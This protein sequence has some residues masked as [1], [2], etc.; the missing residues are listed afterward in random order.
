MMRHAVGAVVVTAMVLGCNP[1]GPSMVRI[2][3]NVAAEGPGA[4]LGSTGDSLHA[5]Y[6]LGATVSFTVEHANILLDHS[7]WTAEAQD[8]AVAVVV[9]STPE[10][11][12]FKTD[13]RM[14]GEG[15]TT[16]RILDGSG[17]LVRV[18][19]LQVLAPNI[20]RFYPAGRIFTANSEADVPEHIAPILIAAGGK[21]SFMVRMFANSDELWGTGGVTIVNNSPD[22]GP[23]T[24]LDS[25]PAFGLRRDFIVM[26]A[27]NGTSAV[28]R[29]FA[30]NNV[31]LRL[32]DV[33]VV[34]PAVITG[35]TVFKQD[36]SKADNDTA[37]V[38]AAE[39]RDA[40]GAT[41]FGAPARWELG[42]AALDGQGDLVRYAVDR[43]QKKMLVGRVGSAEA[44]VELRAKTATVGTTAEVGCAQSGP[45][46]LLLILVAL[47]GA[48]RRHRQG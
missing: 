44:S 35:L 12:T 10:K 5:P 3:D 24:R 8:V 48:R 29:Q 41:V 1:S 46:P 22:T 20:M 7:G 38:V 40:T 30:A 37:L 45:A 31:T 9:A 33:N 14:T 16:L 2:R 28:T 21:T 32:M 13:V 4:R 23:T 26:E 43:K 19:V 11:G 6:A 15:Q 25:G 18:A 39:G 27:P 47:W 42:G 34:D 36:D 17:K